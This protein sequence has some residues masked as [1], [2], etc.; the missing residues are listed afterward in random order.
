M[1]KNISTTCLALFEKSGKEWNAYCPEVNIT[2][3]GETHKITFYLIV[4]AVNIIYDSFVGS[5]GFLM[6][7]NKE[8]KENKKLTDKIYSII[9]NGYEI[10]PR[11]S[12]Q[13]NLID[14]IIGDN[15]FVVEFSLD[16]NIKL[17]YQLEDE[18]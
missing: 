4:K 13:E 1:A 7:D 3:S 17:I 11:Q 2:I 6:G 18:E 10:S 16:G 15:P 5:D 12:N 9:E 8:E 14:Y